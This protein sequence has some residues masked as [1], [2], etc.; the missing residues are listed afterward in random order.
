MASPGGLLMTLMSNRMQANL[1]LSTFISVRQ[2]LSNDCCRNLQLYKCHV[3]YAWE[4]MR[5]MLLSE[6]N[7]LQ[8]LQFPTRMHCT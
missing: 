7:Q 3:V 6:S 1:T 4:T 2:S 8:V 5:S